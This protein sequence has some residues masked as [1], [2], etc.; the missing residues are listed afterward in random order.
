VFWLKN[1]CPE[2]REEHKAP[3]DSD[4]I[5]QAVRRFM[6]QRAQKGRKATSSGIARN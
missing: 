3:Q 4:D 2:F 6:W 1:R 5:T